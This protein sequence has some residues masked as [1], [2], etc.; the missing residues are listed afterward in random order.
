MNT[1]G[2]SGIQ[3]ALVS[4]KFQ[5]RLQYPDMHSDGNIIAD[6]LRPTLKIIVTYEEP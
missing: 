1:I 3:A 2:I 5:I 6:V 4:N